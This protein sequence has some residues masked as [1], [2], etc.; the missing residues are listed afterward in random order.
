MDTVVTAATRL[1]RPIRSGCRLHDIFL[2]LS[3]DSQ[4]QILQRFRIPVRAEATGKLSLFLRS[5]MPQVARR[6]SEPQ[7]GFIVAFWYMERPLG[8]LPESEA[9]WANALLW[10]LRC[11]VAGSAAPARLVDA[12]E[13]VVR[14]DRGALADTEWADCRRWAAF[15]ELQACRGRLRSLVATSYAKVTQELREA[16]KEGEGEPGA[17]WTVL[18]SA[19]E[20]IHKDV[21]QTRAQ[22]DAIVVDLSRLTSR[23]EI[24]VE[25][26]DLATC[27]EFSVSELLDSAGRDLLQRLS[28]LPVRL[29]LRMLL[30]LPERLAPPPGERDR[31]ELAREVEAIRF[32][33]AAGDA[34]VKPISV[35]PML[36]RLARVV[37]DRDSD[38]LA[39]EELAERLSWRFLENLRTGRV[40]VLPGLPP[41]ENSL[42]TT[43]GAPHAS[44]AGVAEAEPMAPASAPNPDTGDVLDLT[45]SPPAAGGEDELPS[46]AVAGDPM[47][48]SWPDARNEDVVEGAEDFSG[49][50]D[51][52]G[53][54]VNLQDV[55]ETTPEAESPVVPV[56]LIE[57]GEMPALEAPAE[58]VASLPPEP[59]AGHGAA[60]PRT[61]E[62]F[63]ALL[64]SGQFE[65]LTLLSADPEG[66]A[67]IPE[68]LAEIVQFGLVYLPGQRRVDERLREL[69]SEAGKH[70]EALTFDSSLLLTAA[71]LRPA[72]LAPTTC[73][74]FLLDALTANLRDLPACTELLEEVAEFA[75]R[76]TPIPR[77]A[78]LGR[79]NEQAR[80]AERR[81]LERE[82]KEWFFAAP[83][84][85][86]KFQAATRIWQTW[87]EPGGELRRLLDRASRP[88]ADASAIQAQIDEWR[89]EDLFS[90]RVDQTDAQVNHRQKGNPV[91]F[92]AL[93][94]LSR[95]TSEALSL[96]ERWLLVHETVAAEADR[97]HSFVIRARDRVRVLATPVIALLGTPEDLPRQSLPEIIRLLR[98]TLRSFEADGGHFALSGWSD[99]IIARERQFL[100]LPELDPDERRRDPEAILPA[101]ERHIR[102]P[103]HP[104]D[105]LRAHLARGRLGAA[106]LVLDRFHV[107]L[108][109]QREGLRDEVAA[110]ARKFRKQFEA[111]IADTELATERAFIGAAI[112]ELCKARLDAALQGARKSLEST[113][114]DPFAIAEIVDQVR[115]V[116]RQIAVDRDAQV[117]RVQADLLGRLGALRTVFRQ[118]E[119]QM[120][121]GVEVELERAIAEEDLGVAV[122]ILTRAE[123]WLKT[124]EGDPREILPPT[125]GVKDFQA[126]LDALESLHPALV[127]ANAFN[128][129][130]QSS[131]V[132]AL[133]A[134]SSLDPEQQRAGQ[135]AFSSWTQ[136]NG[137]W[138]PVFESS[139]V[140]VL[141]WLGFTVR[142]VVRGNQLRL[143][144]PRPNETVKV[145]A[146][147]ASPIPRFGTLS[148]GEQEVII[149]PAG[150][151]E[152]VAQTVAGRSAKD[153]P[154]TILFQGRLDAAGRRR[155]IHAFRRVKECPLI[156]DR[157][158]FAWSC[159]LP[160]GERSAAVFGAGLPGGSN[161]PYTP[162]V[163]G[164]VPRELF[165]GRADDIAQLAS[166]HGPCI[167]YGG[168]QLGKSAMLQQLVQRYHRPKD[169]IHVL[170]AGIAHETDVWELFRRL[171]DRA[172]LLR[173]RLVGAE[174][175]KNSILNML[176][177]HPTRRILVL[178]DE[179]DAL[180]DHDSGR[181]FAHMAMVR[182]LMTESERRFKVVLTG[183]HNVQ[184]FKRI[185]NQP[186]AHFGEPL[187]VTPLPPRHA[188]ELIERP[189]AA[190]GYAFE[191]PSLVYRILANTNCHASL[192]QLVCHALV[193]HMLG[194]NRGPVE[195][196]P[197]FVITEQTI[198]SVYR[199][200]QLSRQMQQRFDWTLDLDARY[201]AIGYIF[202]WMALTQTDASG[203]GTGSPAAIMRELK[204]LWPAAFKTMR[205]EEFGG[206]LDELVGL[207]ILL[208]DRAHGTY[209]LRS[210]NVLRLLGSA[211]KVM[212]EL[213]SLRDRDY[214]PEWDPTTVR[215]VRSD[216]GRRPSPLSVRHES[217]L[218]ERAR[219]IDFIVGSRA[220]GIDEVVA[221][222]AE[223]FD[224][225]PA[226]KFAEVVGQGDANEDLFTVIRAK[227][228]DTRSEGTRLVVRR[229]TLDVGRYL[230]GIQRVLN[231]LNTLT[232]KDKFVR[233][234]FVLGAGETFAMHR[235]PE[236]AAVLSHEAVRKFALRRWPER[237]LLHWI[238]DVGRQPPEP[239]TIRGWM[240]ESGGWRTLIEPRLQEFLGRAVG[241]RVDEAASDFLDD[242]GLAGDTVASR[243]AALML[244]LGNGRFPQDQV[245]TF[246]AELHGLEAPVV[247][248]T[249]RAML[250]LDLLR[251][252]PEKAEV[253]LDPV[254]GKLMSRQ[255]A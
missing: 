102:A 76:R 50:P 110:E 77:G 11:E 90:S 131:V 255:P 109:A 148:N 58:T 149:V 24:P 185:P 55:D 241:R 85:R 27:L 53:E 125:G 209:R 151:L 99:P 103:F 64:K 215:R 245:Q 244:E 104:V 118:R 180:L 116:L 175:I 80:E 161:N 37:V 221:T 4:K 31:T 146:D 143:S 32:H 206:L 88:G 30:T 82:T 191:S 14:G 181:G 193:A 186:L 142:K 184:R 139:L 75:R 235:H 162:E 163:A 5:V 66:S 200:V 216:D 158:L 2:A 78:L 135:Q 101:L 177:E 3:W 141:S 243:L 130:L 134:W 123:E 196:T 188:R 219:G 73:P 97:E 70:V 251:E 107:E 119:V 126:F 46:V 242:A 60:V 168:R 165:V 247:N 65:L 147:I 199:Q 91:R 83:L 150:E 210:T 166:P 225:E 202:V 227:Y 171:L 187:C 92:G 9:T 38:A 56:P 43:S 12:A 10:R 45:G 36:E 189:L 220:A 28:E 42:S 172:S 190:L 155:A 159:A 52:V 67:Q 240:A 160:A 183:L 229:G 138:G 204:S 23:L 34:D 48:E 19:V 61:V 33:L 137:A 51:D 13:A 156:I 71:L 195:Q 128:R 29:R 35:A 59:S 7:A 81:G 120:P 164:S 111:E 122:D 98:D 117:R 106:R 89:D 254:V 226:T 74:E 212:D 213:A 86:N 44:H 192:I 69:Y 47:S 214:V 194:N 84:R 145:E 182:D 218:R 249:V 68:W 232:K 100:L 41:S 197:P 154:L 176:K 63:R 253:L 153:R 201:R 132:A 79:G 222:L 167:V 250:D 169:E 208:A 40:E 17:Q 108:E 49:F 228:T 248:A 105:A 133:P 20:T 121:V 211:D 1:L 236:M 96:C 239:S 136:L 231:W 114:D 246:A 230:S 223:L 217:E 25:L 238:N 233:V 144:M 113:A 198:T 87:V 94:M 112:D 54:P 72:L 179:C 205:D 124:Q 234:I 95:N 16:G 115:D 157:C 140:R 8:E 57:V 26:P 178:L 174:Q 173:E 18:Q 252:D 93:T 6:F 21:L 224:G 62:V 237:G 39:D 207:G 152:L 127:D 15:L 22:M 170:Y 129:S 203:V